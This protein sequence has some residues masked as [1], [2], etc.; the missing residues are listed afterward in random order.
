MKIEVVTLCRE[1]DYMG[2][3][4]DVMT[5]KVLNKYRAVL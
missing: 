4:A 2:L 5:I 1:T 3:F